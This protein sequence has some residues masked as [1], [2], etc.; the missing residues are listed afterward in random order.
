MTFDLSGGLSL[1]SSAWQYCLDAAKAFGWVPAGTEAGRTPP[2]REWSGGYFTNDFQV[3]TDIDARNLAS[4]LDQ[5]IA[6]LK[7]ELPSTDEQRRVLAG[8]CPGPETK[9]EV[10]GWEKALSAHLGEPVAL[11]SWEAAVCLPNERVE[12]LSALAD[13]ARR[14]CFRIM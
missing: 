13:T 3:V 2:G 5:A 10:E 8:E 11:V 1:N 12:V 14:G 7:G 4:A 9:G 6:A